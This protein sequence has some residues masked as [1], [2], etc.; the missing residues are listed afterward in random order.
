MIPGLTLL[1][2]HCQG[3]DPD[4][5]PDADTDADAKP[6]PLTTRL[7]SRKLTSWPVLMRLK[8]EMP[9]MISF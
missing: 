8:L 9:I 2:T 5:D 3:A 7:T 6:W 1:S 4:A